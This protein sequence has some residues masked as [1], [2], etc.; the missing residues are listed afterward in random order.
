MM[1]EFNLPK[2]RAVRILRLFIYLLIVYF[3]SVNVKIFEKILRT[4]F[5]DFKNVIYA[6][7]QPSELLIEH[8]KITFISTSAA[9]VLGSLLSVIILARYLEPYREIV[10]DT[11]SFL[12][13][14]PSVAIIGLVIPVLGYGSLPVI[15]ALVAYSIMPVTLNIVSGIQSVSGEVIEVAR[16][17]GLSETS[18]YLR[19][20]LPLS[21]GVIK[22]AV[23]NV[24]VINVAAATL[25]AIVGA[26]GLGVPIMAGIHDFNPAYV[27]QG[28]IPQAAIALFIEELLG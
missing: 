15:I 4:A 16:G 18:I 12:Q 26:G 11:A 7:T 6:G 2:F 10:I 25:G 23:K 19:I 3:T 20:K 13:T 27:L 17:L 9:I 28:A 22:A 1:Q 8:L 24:L 21:F 5:P 14:L